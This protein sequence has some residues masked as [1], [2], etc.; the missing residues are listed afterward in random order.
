MKRRETALWVSR[1]QG[2]GLV[3]LPLRVP[4]PH[5]PLQVGATVPGVAP[6]HTCACLSMGSEDPT[7]QC[8]EEA[9][10]TTCLPV[11]PG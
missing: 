3:L 7:V 6:C 5:C 4:S 11:R 8:E 10:N 2:G 1:G 9:C